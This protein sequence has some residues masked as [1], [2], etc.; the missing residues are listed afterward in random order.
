MDS[1]P[2]FS[3]EMPI[4][5]ARAPGIVS[6]AQPASWS[7]L[8]ANSGIHRAATVTILA[9][10]EW[11]STRRTLNLHLP[12]APW[13]PDAQAGPPARR[14]AVVLLVHHGHFQLALAVRKGARLGDWAAT[15]PA[16][17]HRCRNNHQS[18]YSW[19]RD[20][21]SEPSGVSGRGFQIATQTN[22]RETVQLGW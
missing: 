19:H 21:R 18:N 11:I 3:Q 5:E 2:S 13:S 10:E 9:D 6:V 12:S 1:S 14:P 20:P 8:R 4:S 7:P 15:V 17:L 22:R 16:H